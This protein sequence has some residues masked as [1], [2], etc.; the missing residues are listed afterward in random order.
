MNGIRNFP[1]NQ[2]LLSKNITRPLTF[3]SIRFTYYPDFI[4]ELQK[5]LIIFGDISKYK[6]MAVGLGITRNDNTVM[7]CYFV[8]LV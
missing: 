1:L 8:F 7:E 5:S 2:Y 6:Q 3:T 4:G